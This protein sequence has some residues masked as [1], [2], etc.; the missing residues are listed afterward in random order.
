[1]SDAVEQF[2][3]A[4]FL[5]GVLAFTIFCFSNCSRDLAAEKDNIKS[6]KQ[7]IVED[8]TYKCQQTNKLEVEK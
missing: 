6:G 5:F 1:M 4:I 7:F 3:S 8:A 2:F